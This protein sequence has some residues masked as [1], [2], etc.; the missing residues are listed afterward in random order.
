M[1]R[2]FT[3]VELLVVIAILGILLSIL[4]PSMSKAREV[5][6]T[7]VCLSNLKQVGVSNTLY[8]TH[9]NNFFPTNRL[10]PTN[11]VRNISWD[12]YLSKYDGRELDLNNTNPAYHPIEKIY[13]CPSDNVERWNGSTRPRTYAMNIN[14]SQANGSQRGIGS[15]WNNI[16]SKSMLE[17]AAPDSTIAYAEMP[18]NRNTV[19]S[20]WSIRVPDRSYNWGA[21]GLLQQTGKSGL[22]GD[23]KFNYLFADGHAQNL[24]VYAT[25]QDI[26][27]DSQAKLMWTTDPDD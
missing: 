8:I 26:T 24:S 16:P 14:R 25:A 15:A 13:H 4:L 20:F 1:N 22:H 17:V 18:M 21:W 10:R 6:K 27:S 12:T 23:Y 9:N 7:A 5:S 19:G 2:K 11:P 3:I